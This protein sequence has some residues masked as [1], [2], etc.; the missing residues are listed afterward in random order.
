MQQIP[1]IFCGTTFAWL[2]TTMKNCIGAR[3][4]SI[5][6]APSLPLPFRGTR[7][8][9]LSRCS[10]FAVTVALFFPASAEAGRRLPAHLQ[11]NSPQN[12]ALRGAIQNRDSAAARQSLAARARAEQSLKKLSLDDTLGNLSELAKS[13]DIE[14]GDSLGNREAALRATGNR[15][16]RF[17]VVGSTQKVG[18]ARVIPVR[19]QG[20]DMK[21]V[22]TRKGTF[23]GDEKAMKAATKTGLFG[24]KTIDTSKLKR[25]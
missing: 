8:N 12:K 22:I 5:A 1:Y 21:V 11:Y 18:D 14:G 13:M 15:S 25:K 17:K 23:V 20:K 6:S 7:K 2:G 16:E 4:T 3:F 9:M 24:G 19:S 10:L